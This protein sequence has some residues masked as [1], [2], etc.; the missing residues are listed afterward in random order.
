MAEKAIKPSLKNPF[1]SDEKVEFNIPGEISRETG[2]YEEVMKEG[3][4][5]IQRPVKSVRIDQIEKQ[6]FKRRMTVW[7]RIR[8][9]T[10]KAPTFCSRTGARTSTA[11]PW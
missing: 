2:A 5:L 7:E 9:L 1:D 8:V 3:Y 6:H 10:D 4:D 11:P